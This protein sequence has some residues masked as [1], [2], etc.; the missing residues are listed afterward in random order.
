MYTS[1]VCDFCTPMGTVRPKKYAQGQR[2][3]VFVVVLYWPSVPISF[4][5]TSLTLG[6]SCIYIWIAKV[7]L[8]QAW[9]VWLDGSQGIH[10][11]LIILLQQIEAQQN[12]VRISWDILYMSDVCDYCTALLVSE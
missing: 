10:E 7:Q 8:K 12:R 9:M 1:N 4:R 3:V 2:F 6:Q 11:A 5:V